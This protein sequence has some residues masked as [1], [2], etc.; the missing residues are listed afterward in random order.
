MIVGAGPTGVELAGTIAELAR[1]TLARRFPPHRSAQRTDHARGGRTARARR[2][3]GTA[4]GLCATRARATRRRGTRSTPQS[5]NRRARG[6]ARHRAHR[7]EY[8]HL[9]SRRRRVTGR[10]VARRATWIA[11]AGS[12]C[13]AISRSRPTRTSSSSAMQRSLKRRMAVACRASRRPRNSK[14]RYVGKLIESRIDGRPQPGPFA[15]RNPGNL[16]T[17]GR[18][19][20]MIEFPLSHAARLACMV[21]LG[22]RAHLFSGRRAEPVADLDPVALGVPHLRP[23]RAL[24]HGLGARGLSAAISSATP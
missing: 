5:R 12:G 13:A 4:V 24:D 6:H 23:R 1:H 22:H 18:R 11:P 3:P 16:A 19:R 8:D 10:Q 20:A 21:D 7:V 14:A 2:I 17:I 15:Y 9:G